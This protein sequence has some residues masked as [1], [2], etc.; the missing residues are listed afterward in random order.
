M[1]KHFTGAINK[2]LPVS[3]IIIQLGQLLAS[4]VGNIEVCAFCRTAKYYTQWRFNPDRRFYSDLPTCPLYRMF[5][6]VA[7]GTLIIVFKVVT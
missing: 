5:H 3:T 6:C 1:K 2:C 7:K 4:V